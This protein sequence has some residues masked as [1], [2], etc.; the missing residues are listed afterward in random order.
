VRKN[1]SPKCEEYPQ[2]K[3]VAAP[4]K[5]RNRKK[6]AKRPSVVVASVNKEV[7]MGENFALDSASMVMLPGQKEGADKNSLQLEKGKGGGMGNNE[8]CRGWRS[9]TE[10]PAGGGNQK[11]REGWGVFD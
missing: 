1:R 4:A 10:V 3:I 9:Q 7:Q 6:K 8:G 2:E 5:G 11:K